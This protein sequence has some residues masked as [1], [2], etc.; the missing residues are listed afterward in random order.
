MKEL[1]P[2]AVRYT[3]EKLLNSLFSNVKTLVFCLALAVMMTSVLPAMVLAADA[4]PLDGAMSYPNRDNAIPTYP[5]QDSGDAT[6]TTTTMDST[7]NDGDEDTDDAEAERPVF[8][9]P[10][11]T[12][13]TYRHPPGHG[14]A[15][16]AGHVAIPGHKPLPPEYGYASRTT[17]DDITP[18]DVM[19]AIGRRLYSV[20]HDEPE[21]ALESLRQIELRND[22]ALVP[23][24]VHAMQF[25]LLGEARIADTLRRITG[26]NPGKT[27]FAWA[28]WLESHPDLIL[29]PG[30]AQAVVA[31]WSAIDGKYRAILPPNR[32]TQV[33]KASIYWDGTRVDEV[34]PVIKP[35]VVGPNQAFDIDHNDL[36][37]GV[38][39][40]GTYRAYPVSQLL[41]N[42]I[43]NDVLGDH[44]VTIA[45]EPLCGFPIAIDRG[46]VG[47]TSMA[48]M[49]WAGLVYRSSRLLYTLDGDQQLWDPCT[50]RSVTGAASQ[51]RERLPLA[52]ATFT[53]WSAW[54][55]A[56]PETTVMDTAQAP[57]ATPDSLERYDD[58]VGAESLIYPAYLNSTALPAKE[59][60]LLVDLGD[61]D[62]AIRLADLKG[63]AVINHRFGDQ[64]VVIIVENPINCT[65]RVFKR[66]EGAIFGPSEFVDRVYGSGGG[67][68]KVTEDALISPSGEE[69]E[70]MPARGLFWFSVDGLNPIT[71]NKAKQSASLPN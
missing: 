22:M 9:R 6:A 8:Y 10:L 71:E 33:P 45:Y 49:A 18:L 56:Y 27:W 34:D 68:W 35:T 11:R 39:L 13:P 23:P 57:E 64:G 69:L 12:D 62:Q 19:D 24:L 65:I 52:N 53:S 28:Q 3:R 46:H 15:K 54:R 55:S 5:A 42:P 70:R 7:D 20:A 48:P 31:M 47:N 38:S 30:L 37:L 59:R 17:F 63:K 67:L 66:P 61:H 16:P 44:E 29:T 58:Y 2:R 60:M 26:A 32:V 51:A 41:A 14:A 21:G 25:S 40:N 36:V 43:I 1:P 4:P 50:M